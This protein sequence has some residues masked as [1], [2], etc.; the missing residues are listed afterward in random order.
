MGQW[1][2]FVLYLI[3]TVLSIVGGYIP[4]YFV[5]RRGMEPTRDA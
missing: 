1:L 3:V 5:E 4:K 2:I